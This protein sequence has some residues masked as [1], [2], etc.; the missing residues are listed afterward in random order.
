MKH[1]GLILTLLTFITASNAQEVVSVIEG[2]QVKVTE[3]AENKA[4]YEAAIVPYRS[5]INRDLDKVLAYNPTILDKSKGK[6]QSN[7]GDLLAKV[8][9]EKGNKVFEERTKNKVDV[10]ILNHGGIRAM[11]G[12]GNVSA[13]NAFEVMPFENAAVVLEIEGKY[14]VEFVNFFLKEKKPHPID[15]MTF[16]ITADG[17]YKDLKIKNEPIVLDKVYNLVTNDY[18]ASGGDKMEFLKNAK[19]TH[20]LDYKLRSMLI[21]YFEDVDVVKV[22]TEIKI[23]QE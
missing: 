21:D 4:D 5:Q 7:I 23:I 14:L 13:R 2:K 11:I 8:T 9:L 15:G 6:W 20:P 1:F 19:K 18:L 3:A 10:C 17:K 16:K 12:Q 22:P